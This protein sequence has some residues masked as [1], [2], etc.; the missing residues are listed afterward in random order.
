MGKLRELA[1][2]FRGVE[3]GFF[4]AGSRVYS[5][6]LRTGAVLPTVPKRVI[7]VY[8]MWD[9]ARGIHVLVDVLIRKPPLQLPVGVVNMLWQ[10]VGRAESS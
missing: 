6:E 3:E 5:V 1:R 9:H 2:Q 7:V 4:R 10:C 8:P